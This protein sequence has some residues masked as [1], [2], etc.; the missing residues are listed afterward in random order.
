MSQDGLEFTKLAFTV[1]CDEIFID[2]TD[3]FLSHLPK[4]LKLDAKNSHG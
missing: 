1:C 2:P 4:W 3:V